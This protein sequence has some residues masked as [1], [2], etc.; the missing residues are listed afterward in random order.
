MGN[1]KIKIPAIAASFYKATDMPGIK[2]RINEIKTKYGR[3]I[4]NS[5]TI[6]D[7]NEDLIASFIFIESAGDETVINKS[8]KATG[9]MQVTPLSAT[10]VLTTE[11]NKK[12]LNDKEKAVLSRILGPAK[13][14]KVI[15]AQM[16]DTIITQQDLLNPELNILIGTIY[17]GIIIDR[18][19][20]GGTV[21]LDK[22]VVAYNK[23]MYAFKSGKELVG[24]PEKL[25]ASLPRETSDYIKKLVGKNGVLDAIV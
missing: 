19:T 14:S 10:D 17:L 4:K 24:T 5:A 8:S 21:R 18:H 13:Y 25:M 7:V 15:K 12:R 3:F 2:G 11:R 1:L 20:E 22:V 23:G 9:L 16:G 6:S